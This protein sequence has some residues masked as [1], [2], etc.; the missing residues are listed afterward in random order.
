MR[1]EQAREIYERCYD[2]W[3][4]G[5]GDTGLR[6]LLEQA[7]AQ[8]LREEREQGDAREAQG[9]QRGIED[10]AKEADYYVVNSRIAENIARGILALAKQGG[11]P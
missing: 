3:K 6:F 4:H 7:I 5:K 11:K 10:A 8:A 2:E 9:Y 1:E